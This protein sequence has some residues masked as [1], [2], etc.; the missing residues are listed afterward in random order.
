MIKVIKNLGIYTLGDLFNYYNVQIQ[1]NLL[2]KIIW[3]INF[4]IG[5]KILNDKIG[6]NVN[7]DVNF[8]LWG[9]KNA[10]NGDGIAF[11]INSMLY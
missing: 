8:S 2:M 9:E 3:N 10:L 7:L 5:L 4:V 1:N 11:F 6:N